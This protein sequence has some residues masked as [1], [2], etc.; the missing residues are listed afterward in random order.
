MDSYPV[1]QLERR[2][3]PSS[4]SKD[5]RSSLGKLIFPSLCQIKWMGV[6]LPNVIALFV[7]E[8]LSALK[9]VL[10]NELLIP[11]PARVKKR[12]KGE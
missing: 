1:L 12:L 9:H 2:N 7:G 3:C 11:L 5:S 6:T 4:Q 8:E 10:L